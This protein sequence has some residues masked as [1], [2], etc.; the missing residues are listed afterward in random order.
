MNAQELFARKYTGS[1]LEAPAPVTG[2]KVQ[3]ETSG[4]ICDC[5]PDE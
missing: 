2:C 1:N 5:D 4:M 3:S